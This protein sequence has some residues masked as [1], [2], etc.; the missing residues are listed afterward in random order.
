MT[1]ALT[2]RSIRPTVVDFGEVQAIKLDLDRV[3]AIRR[4]CPGLDALTDEEVASLYMCFEDD[5]GRFAGIFFIGPGGR[6]C[7]FGELDKAAAVR[8]LRQ[9]IEE[10]LKGMGRE[11]A[12]MVEQWVRQRWG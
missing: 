12:R 9:R 2:R 6:I 8:I 11:Y 1:T 5:T 7:S 10:E 4:E 3:Q